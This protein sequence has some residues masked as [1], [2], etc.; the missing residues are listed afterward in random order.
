MTEAIGTESI[1][2]EEI[3]Q[4]RYSDID[5]NKCLKPFSLLNF[6]QD[7]ASDNAERLGFGYSVIY[8]KNL[9]WVLLKYRIEFEEYPYD[10][11]DLTLKTEPRGYNKLFAYRNFELSQ[12]GKTIAK[13]SSVWSLVDFKS[14]KM[15]AIEDNINTPY[16]SKMV[17]SNKDLSFNKIPKISIADKEK[18]FEVRY[19]DI[20]VNMHA[21]NGNY[22]VWA[23]EPLPIEFKANHK[24]KSL[25]MVFKKEIKYGEKLVSKTQILENNTT[26]HELYNKD[27]KED[28]C[29]ICCN[30][31]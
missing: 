6:F 1:I 23:F 13:A 8:P 14:K 20:D 18:E 17:P 22:I 31:N 28:L 12:S 11:N 4:I 19:N 15:A 5:Y 3:I 9:M 30:W 2:S 7:I 21:N 25:D 24:I 16:F 10:I 26:I 29:N 27:T